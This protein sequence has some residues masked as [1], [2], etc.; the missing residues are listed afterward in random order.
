MGIPLSQR[1]GLS[2]ESRVKVGLKKRIFQDIAINYMPESLVNRKKGFTVSMQRDEEAELFARSLPTHFE[3][4][5]LKN[6]EQRF[7]AGILIQW[8]QENLN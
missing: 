1:L 3:S 7:A 2:D 8:M 6:D 4:I 5:K